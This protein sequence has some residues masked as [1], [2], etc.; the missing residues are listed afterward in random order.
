[1]AVLVTGI[2]RADEFI[3][4]TILINAPS[5]VTYDFDGNRL[6]IP[7]FITGGDVTAVMTIGTKDR[8]AEG[9]IQ[10]GNLGWHYVNRIDTVCYVSP[11]VQLDEGSGVIPWDGLDNY[12]Y[13][14]PFGEYRYRIW[15]V[16]LSEE[17]PFVAKGLP[18]SNS[19]LTVQ[20]T[21][22]AGVPIERPLIYSAPLLTSAGDGDNTAKRMRWIIGDDPDNPELT[23][24]T[25]YPTWIERGPIAIS[26]YFEDLFLTEAVTAS[27]EQRIRNFKWV[28]NG[29][30]ILQE[31]W[32]E[33]GTISF[34]A[35]T[36]PDDF[37]M[38]GVASL[39]E[40]RAFFLSHHIE[41]GDIVT[42][43]RCISFTE[44]DVGT[45]S[46]RLDEWWNDGFGESAFTGP[47]AMSAR[48]GILYLGSSMSSLLMAINPLGGS[49]FHDMIRYVNGFGDGFG[50][51]TG[52]DGEPVINDPSRSERTFSLAVDWHGYM[53][54]PQ[55][56][57]DRAMIGVLAP[58]G[59]GI[60]TFPVDASLSNGTF[61]PAIISYGSMY[62]GILLADSERDEVR[63]L[64]Q[65]SVTG[66]L[67]QYCE[68]W[69][70]RGHYS[71]VEH[72]FFGGY[73]EFDGGIRAD[74]IP[75]DTYVDVGVY[76]PS[77][78]CV[79]YKNGCC[80]E[81]FYIDRWSKRTYQLFADNP[82][83]AEVDGL[84][85]GDRLE[86]RLWR[87]DT[88]EEYTLSVIFRDGDG[89]FHP[90]ETVYVDS[91][92]VEKKVAVDN[93]SPAA[94]AL[95]QNTPNPFNPSTSISYTLPEAVK[96]KLTVYSALGTEVGTIVDEWQP[97]G[98][99]TVEWNGSG[100]SSAVYFYR[101]EAGGYTATKRMVLVK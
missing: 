78:H 5:F 6:E 47:S 64:G 18:V 53:I 41:G 37:P 55:D 56:D 40:D 94:F 71:P 27:G 28:S 25:Q 4:S 36:P 9:A 48:N 93:A 20:I 17:T 38:S 10:N 63:W 83:T 61:A 24:T 89:T 82:A 32:G 2:S 88:Q 91:L 39:D 72:R 29:N 70:I 75:P 44:G 66:T 42:D 77:G 96:V 8:Y 87:D 51:L 49:D 23:E 50:D 57:P 1:M 60:G 90:G 97:A 67:G 11:P 52:D 86:F 7:C 16:S 99:H 100:H 92:I 34:P 76:S 65:D 84:R 12:G 3:P 26:P 73:L 45:P 79:G 19:P 58:D 59:T 68:C 98:V 81:L 15:A 30:A 69:G 43:L 80:H 31:D 35:W 13:M 101:I 21:D 62:D 14:L 33:E 74:D 22:E 54:F 46:V 85:D 95:D